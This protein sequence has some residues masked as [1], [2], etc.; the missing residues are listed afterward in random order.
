[1]IDING[2]EWKESLWLVNDN[3][4]DIYVILNQYFLDH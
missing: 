1:V 2:K 3:M 4:D